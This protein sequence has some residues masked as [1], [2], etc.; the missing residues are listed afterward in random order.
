M[1]I[2]PRL[3]AA[4]GGTGIP[5]TGPLRF[6]VHTTETLNDPDAWIPGWQYPSHVVACPA[7]RKVRQCVSLAEAA[8]SLY[9]AP[10]GVQTNVEGAYQ[11]EIN[12][13]SVD[14]ANP[15]PDLTE[16]DYRWLA[17]AVFA[18]MAKAAVQAGSPINHG[19]VLEPGP[20]PG[21]ARADAAQRMSFDAWERFDGW[22][23][24]RHVPENDHW[25][26]G[27]L[28]LAKLARY[29]AEALGVP[30]PST[31]GDDLMLSAFMLPT[32]AT[33]YV[34]NP[35]T[36]YVVRLDQLGLT[37]NTY[38]ELVARGM[39]RPF[40]PSKPLSWEANALLAYMDAPAAFATP[41]APRA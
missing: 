19:N 29:T 11:V 25:D 16:D 10:G 41:R 37:L 3:D 2:F 31:P 4:V 20:I 35:A 26:A 24:H 13:L 15:R 22:C 5:F 36:G 9:N 8:K 21:S 27:A 6:V 32:G 18:P 40:D 23:G 38:N 34:H 17:V 28:D 7:R 1:W 30:P 14:P 12:C 33:V 39:A